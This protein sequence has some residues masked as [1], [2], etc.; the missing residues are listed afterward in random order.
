MY[1]FFGSFMSIVTTC[2]GKSYQSR[3]KIEGDEKGFLWMVPLLGLYG[4]WSCSNLYFAVLW[5]VSLTHDLAKS[6]PDSLISSLFFNALVNL[7]S[8]IHDSTLLV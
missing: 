8:Y 4:K 7:S 2:D 5:G 1:I 6:Q 3:K